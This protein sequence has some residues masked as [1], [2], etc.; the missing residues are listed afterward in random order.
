MVTQIP[1]LTFSNGKTVPAVGYGTWQSAPGEVGAATAHAI[2]AGYRHLDLAKVYQNQKEIG[3]AIAESGVP[4]AELFITSKLWN[5]QH[6]PENVEP[7]LDDTLQELGLTYL[8]LYLIHWPV[9]FPAEGDQNQNLFPKDG[10]EVKIDT[11]TTLVDT[12]KAMIKLLDTGKVKSIG[13]S[14]FNAEMVDAIIA[15]T[16][17]SPVVNQIER[18]PKLLQPELLKHHRSKNILITAYSG[19]GNNTIGEPLLVT[20][21]TVKKIAEQYNSNPGAILVSWGVQ[22]CG[23][24]HTIIPKSVTPSRIEDNF[25]YVELKADDIAA[26]D[27]IGDESK[28]GVYRRYNVPMTYSPKWPINVFGEPDEKPAKHSVNIQ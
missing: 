11:K 19:F 6:A 21:P 18:H 22:S 26:I 12:W 17:V 23:G 27:A 15:A 16:G 28:G 25:K 5:S 2:K 9:A 13:V 10:D 1:T 14:N 24:G 4:R 8:D 3:P 20:H 7:A